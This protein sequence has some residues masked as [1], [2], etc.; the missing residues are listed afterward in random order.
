VRGEAKFRRI[1]VLDV[2]R[3][4]RFQDAD[5]AA[6][7][8]FVCKRAGINVIYCAEEFNNEGTVSDYFAKH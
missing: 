3:W 7:Y 1:I 5:E 6:H 2:S 8:E 4:G